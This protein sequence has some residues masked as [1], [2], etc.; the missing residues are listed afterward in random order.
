MSA[1]PS[2]DCSPSRPS[3]K[4][5]GRRSAA[6]STAVRRGWSSAET[7]IQPDLER[8]R[9]G[10]SRHTSQRKEPDQVRILSGVFEGRTTGTPIGLVIEN[11]DQRS[12]DYEKIKDRFRP[13][14]RRLHVSAEVRLSRLSRRRPLFGAR[15]RHARRRRRDRA[16]VPARAAR[17]AHS[18]LPRAARPAAVSSPSRSGG[19]R[20]TIRSSARIPRGR[21]ARS[22]HDRAA[23]RRATRSA[24]ASTSSRPACRPGSASRCST[25]SMPTSRYAMMG[26]NAVKGVEIGAGFAAV[27]QS[28][29]Q[30]RD[31]M[32]PRGLPVEQCRRRARRHFVRPG[33]RGQHRAQ[34]DVEHRHPGAHD[35]RRR[36]ER[37][38]RHDRSS[39][40]VRRLAR[41]PIAEAMLALVLD[42]SLPAPP[43]AERGRAVAHARYHPSTLKGGLQRKLCAASR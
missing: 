34:A 11:E 22:L 28:G 41:R 9:T 4:A 13:G 7:D 27:E 21:G 38:G 3:A 14:S 35:R 40:S 16:Q 23:P 33:H 29:S 5:T 12:R 1:T 20:T 24:R 37:R 30:H 6:S 36:R 32:T 19:G 10:T 2:A 26:I 15:D 18:G 25:S 42:G 39:R 43:R 8:R 17:G 31:E